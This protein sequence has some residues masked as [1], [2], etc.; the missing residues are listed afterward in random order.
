MNQK[1]KNENCNW[2]K[3]TRSWCLLNCK[4]QVKNL[5]E[6]Y[7]R[8]MCWERKWSNA[9]C[10]HLSEVLCPLLGYSDRFSTDWP[11][12]WHFIHLNPKNLTYDCSKMGKLPLELDLIS[13]ISCNT[14]WVFVIV[15]VLLLG[16]ERKWEGDTETLHTDGQLGSIRASQLHVL[17]DSGIKLL[18]ER[19]V[20][21]LLFEPQHPQHSV[22][23][24]I[25]KYFLTSHFFLFCKMGIIVLSKT[26]VI[27]QCSEMKQR[28]H[29]AHSKLPS[30][31]DGSDFL[32]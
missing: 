3:S 15:V 28:K 32:Y 22:L 31:N 20:S 10:S 23:K 17:C 25:S 19:T 9:F 2:K 6:R 8:K 11:Y 18:M 7:F 12:C 5:W 30:I 21:Y 13:V 1:L 24:T 27:T 16:L 26:V 14:L 29:L 4:H